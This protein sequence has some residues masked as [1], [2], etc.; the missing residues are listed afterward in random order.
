LGIIIINNIK[1]V[2]ELVS[3]ERVIAVGIIIIVGVG[4]LVGTSRVNYITSYD[5]LSFI[6]FS[7]PLATTFFF[8]HTCFQV[9]LLLLLLLLVRVWPAVAK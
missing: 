4:L 1:I 6:F 7:P 5:V 8:V 9:I 3:P 2:V